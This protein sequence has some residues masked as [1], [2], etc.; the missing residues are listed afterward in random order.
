MALT[1]AG[2]SNTVETWPP[3]NGRFLRVVATR[4]PT[5]GPKFPNKLMKP[6]DCTRSPS[7]TQPATIISNMPKKKNTVPTRRPFA[8]KMFFVPDN[9]VMRK[10]PTRKRT[11]PTASNPVSP[12][13]I[14]PK[15][16]NSAPMPQSIM[17]IFF[18]SS[19]I[20]V[21]KA[22]KYGSSGNTFWTT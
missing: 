10:H 8:K 6:N 14:T 4:E 11:S 5:I 9:P 20:E 13:S 12:K 18:W 3:T 17:P 15:K 22:K 19:N 7:L 1:T 2:W 16:K 21:G